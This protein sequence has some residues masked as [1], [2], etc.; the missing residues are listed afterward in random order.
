MSTLQ[1]YISSFIQYKRSLG[2]TYETAERHLKNFKQF[3]DENYPDISYPTKECADQFLLK[4]QGQSGGLYNMLSALREFG[5]YIYSLGILD[6]YIVPSKHMPKMTAD[7][8]YFFTPEEID[9][10]FVGID[11]YFS[12]HKSGSKG[13]YI[14]LPAMLRLIHCCGL[15]PKEARTLLLKNVHLSEGYFDVIQSKGPKN[16]RIYISGDLTD[17]LNRYNTIISGFFQKRL[18]FFPKQESSFYSEGQLDY[19]FKILWRYSFPDFEGDKTPRLYDLR[20]YFA[21]TNINNWVREGK[22]VNAMLPYLMR[23]MGHNCIK[24]T[25]YYFR[26]V[27]DFYNDFKELTKELNDCIQEVIT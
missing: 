27:P 24:H 18:Y 23:Y 17:Y 1:E 6:V 15:R 3:A 13:R 25:L 9:S 14:V 21:W 7:S 4:Y 19:A 5:R 22:D 12:V 2:Y 26:F 20:H 16:R 11:K 8:P 10:L